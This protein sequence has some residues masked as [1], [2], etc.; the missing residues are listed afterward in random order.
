MGNVTILP[1]APIRR[2][3]EWHV[4]LDYTLLEGNWFIKDTAI[5]DK[6]TRLRI[7]EIVCQGF[8]KLAEKRW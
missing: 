8:R 6:R 1:A 7:I 4:A 3:Y 5:E 2:L